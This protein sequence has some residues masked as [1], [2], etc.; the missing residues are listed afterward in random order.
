LAALIEST[1]FTRLPDTDGRDYVRRCLRRHQPFGVITGSAP[2]RN[3]L[4]LRITA[5]CAVHDSL[6]TVRVAV[7]TESA[8]AFLSVCLGQLGFELFDATLDNLHDLMVVFLR[9]ESARG[10]RTVV[11]VEKAD[12]CGLPVFNCMRALS[13]VRAGATPGITFVLT[14]SPDLHRI[15]D[16]PDIAGLRQST[17]Q[18]FDLDRGL[19]S[20]ETA[21]TVLA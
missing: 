15:L 6:H 8:Q 14:G 3:A 5:D 4:V 19:V 18:R 9:H 12:H 1:A 13:R 21:R 10:R 17:R 2:D 11:I 20:T 7:P 16:S